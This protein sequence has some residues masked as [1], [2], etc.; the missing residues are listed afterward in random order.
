MA[1]PNAAGR[2]AELKEDRM[3]RYLRFSKT[4]CVVCCAL[5]LIFASG[6]LAADVANPTATSKAA[7][8]AQNQSNRDDSPSAATIS[9]RRAE[10]TVLGGADP[11]VIVGSKTPT[12]K[13]ID[14]NADEADGV[15]VFAL[16]SEYYVWWDWSGSLAIPDQG[17]WVGIDCSAPTGVPSG[18]VV[19]EVMLH[20]QITHTYIGDLEAKVYN[21]SGTTWT[22]RNMEGGSDD[23]IDETKTEES[24]FDGDDP[25]Q[26]WYYRVRDTALMDT[27]TLDAMQLYVY[28]DSARP[29]LT[30]YT[31]TG[32][33]DK[34]VVSN[35]TGTNTDDSPLSDTDALYVDWAAINDGT[36]ATDVTFY[37]QLYVDGALIQT[38]YS[39]PPL[40]PGWYVVG[41]DHSIG[42]LPDGTHTIKIVVDYDNRVE[43]GD[44]GNNEFTKTITVGSSGGA[45]NLTPYQPAA[46]SDKI[47][48]SN[49][50]GTNTDDSTLYETDTLY[51]D[52]AAINNG[53]VATGVT[54]YSQLYVDGVLKNSWYVDPPLDPG[55]YVYIED[56]SIGALAAGPHTVEVIVDYDDRV[57]ESDE[58]DNAYTKNISTIIAG[59]PDI[60][61]EPLVLNFNIS[62]VPPAVKQ[63]IVASPDYFTFLQPDGTPFRAR[64]HG[65]EFYHYMETEDGWTVARNSTTGIYEY[66]N[67]N[68]KG[69]FA[70][71]GYAVGSQDALAMA[72]IPK[73]VRESR[74][75]ASEKRTIAMQLMLSE[76]VK[77]LQLA[78]PAF[79][80]VKS[81]AILANFS[82]TTPTF[83]QTDFD[84]LFNTAGY[85]QNGAIGSV[86]DYYDEASYGNILV[87]TTASQWVNLPNTM[88][89]YGA[90]DGA[91]WDLRPQEMV[92]DA[93][94][95]LDAAGFDF[96]P[97]DTDS[98]GWID[99]FS[100][101]HQG[102]GEEAGGGPD[103]IW[104]HKWAIPTMIVDGVKIS[105]Y[106]TEPEIYGAGLTTIGVIC[107]EF[108]HAIGL[109]DLYD[110]DYSSEGIGN[111]GLMA[112][113]SWNDS[114]RR[115]AHFCS[116]S[117][118]QLGWV[119]ETLL[120]ASQLGIAITPLATNA[121]AYR[122]DSGMGSQ[123]Y[124]LIENRQT[125]GGTFDDSLPASG[126]LAYHIDDNQT[127]NDNENRY[128]VGVLQADGLRHLENGIN[129]GDAGDP[130]PGST[131]KRNLGPD[132]NPNTNS[133]YNGPTDIDI[134]NISNSQDTMSFDLNLDGGVA[135]GSF[136]I[137]ND[138]TGL[139]SVTSITPSTSAP[140]ISY[141]P[142]TPF[143]V[144]AG[145]QQTVR[146]FIDF[147]QAPCGETT[148]TLLVSSNDPDESPYPG[149]V[150]IVVANEPC[151]GNLPP[152]ISSVTAT[153]STISEIQTSQ[154]QVLATDPD[155]GPSPLTYNWIVL[156]GEG[157]VDNAAIANPVYTPPSV[158][159]TQV[160]TLTIDVSDGE[161]VTQGTIDVTVT[162]AMPPRPPRA[163]DASDGLFPGRV[164]VRWLA[165]Q[166]ADDYRVFRAETISGPRTPLGGW[167][168]LRSLNDTTA[169][170]GTTYYYFIRS[171]NAAGI[172]RFSR[173]DEGWLQ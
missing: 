131:S 159:G 59:D 40:D 17:G 128:W 42:S 50:T 157:S 130:F 12:R 158:T 47:V 112:G 102:P 160:F 57:L 166:N 163:V 168:T 122:I 139:L 119:T 60:R 15:L 18:S 82:D 146:V 81:L 43:E 145:G 48:V 10:S 1:S 169:A 161:D 113:G 65:D 109:P 120:D 107:H 29:D 84:G 6:T 3:E 137:Y 38:W 164:L 141:S 124:L 165:V 123:E 89:Y 9:M 13:A 140:W 24:I 105:E 25:T 85:N 62:S 51:V 173:P 66:L 61:I 150:D 127:N 103:T 153:P 154:L 149:G 77:D 68:P 75:I 93:I 116:W 144:A 56:Y 87:D 104:S 37:T 91:G 30:P 52:W 21:D 8:G 99:S 118:I 4:D 92:A 100:V 33:S 58:A 143:D 26:Q 115:P 129:R 67:T 172:S 45:P 36:L 98:D 97:F 167:R 80:T 53:T 156:P 11:N 106:H 79:G 70:F 7:V 71:I 27:G 69:E 5:I 55:W 126:L 19:T 133:Y 171:R 2:H 83:A 111:W 54:F 88:A 125:A 117:K 34:I 49:T 35:T 151:G 170:A 90:N 23:N 63:P 101:I 22:V 135:A 152:T 16:A 44:E 32:W 155:S 110:T 41:E 64:K 31:P 114:G 86:R 95:A 142:A 94:T 148:T 14:S 134:S 108:G 121:Q 46:W 96:A 28:Y 73:H 72:A 39:D 76:S 78:V 136:V 74:Q 132:S 162:D 20:H 147:G 138:G